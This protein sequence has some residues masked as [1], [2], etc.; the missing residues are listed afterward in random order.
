M[1][2]EVSFL[3]FTTKCISRYTPVGSSILKRHIIHCQFP[4]GESISNIVD[5][6]FGGIVNIHSRVIESGEGPCD[7]VLW[8][9]YGDT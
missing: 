2:C 5:G 8:E 7:G 6:I 1:N 4:K 9:G 3:A